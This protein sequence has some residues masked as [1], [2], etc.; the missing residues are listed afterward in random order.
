ME[1]ISALSRYTNR[2]GSYLAPQKGI[3]ILTQ[4][5][6]YRFRFYAEW[7]YFFFLMKILKGDKYKELKETLNMKEILVDEILEYEFAGRQALVLWRSLF[8][9]GC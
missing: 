6:F 8:C 5:A 1:N 7:K 9:M 4:H 2:M 3:P